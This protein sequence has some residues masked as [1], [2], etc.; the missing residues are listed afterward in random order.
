LIVTNKT[1]YI[2]G[3]LA[4]VTV[5][6]MMTVVCRRFLTPVS[7]HSVAGYLPFEGKYEGA[8]RVVDQLICDSD[9]ELIA[10]GRVPSME[11]SSRRTLRGLSRSSQR[12]FS[13]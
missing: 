5:M 2:G 11:A 9:L 12:Q 8:R 1:A 13:V 4:E 6:T 3:L 10:V 7:T